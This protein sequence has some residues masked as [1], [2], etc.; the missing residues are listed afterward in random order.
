MKILFKNRLS[1]VCMLLCSANLF[2]QEEP[3]KEEKKE[4][5][6]SLK[7]KFNEA[8]DK[9]LQFGIWNQT[10]FRYIENNPGTMVN[11]LPSENVY[12][13]GIRRMR[14]STTV[15]LSK[16]FKLFF[17]V[18][19]NNQTFISGGGTAN[20]ADGKGKKAKIFFH[21]AYNEFVVI[22][23]TE[24]FSL[25]VGTGLHSWNGVS[26]LTNASS[27]KM[28][29]ADLPIYNFPTIEMSDQM[30]RQ[31]GIFVHGEYKRLAYR[32]NVN[33]PFATDIKPTAATI[34]VDNN[35]KGNLAT[36][37]YIFYQF[38]DKEAITSSFLPGTY[39]GEKKIF[40]VGA[41]FYSNAEGTTTLNPDSS[42][43]YHNIS[44]FGVDVFTEFPV[45]DP[46]KKMSASLYSVFYDYNFGPNY[47]RTTGIMNPGTVDAG[48]T[49]N[50]VA[51]GAGNARFSMG[52][53]SIWH[54]QAG[55]LLPKFS[56]KIR[57]QPYVV[58]ALKDLEALNQTGHY[59]D[60]GTNF[61]ILDHNAKISLQYSSRPLYDPES[62]KVTQRAG[63][64]L[65]SVQISL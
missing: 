47:I 50:R 27:N 62:L 7:I 1:L 35:Q 44:V 29:T 48:F 5:L 6:G 64:I 20:G 2:A 39:L 46:S 60:I 21:D 59:Y 52:T 63:E 16:R 11:E 49:G 31:F 18:G 23:K 10:W 28:L 34:A 40:N 65:A 13:A 15:Q 56:D 51:E 55:F 53:G 37:G 4:P 58:Y 41:G 45:G 8:G 9:Y 12:D 25:S 42:L 43:S 36:A 19:M 17:Q 26:R 3:A 30:S 54:T 38:K 14:I 61:L 22:P 24:N 57:I 32:F 33:K